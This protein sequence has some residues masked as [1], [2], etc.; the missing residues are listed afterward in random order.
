[1]LP[2]PAHLSVVQVTIRWG[3]GLGT[4]LYRRLEFSLLTHFIYNSLITHCHNNSKLHPKMLPVT[5]S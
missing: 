4:T 2:G 3:W 5:V 1:M